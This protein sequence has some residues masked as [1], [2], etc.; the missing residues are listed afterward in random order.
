MRHLAELKDPISAPGGMWAAGDELLAWGIFFCFMVPTFFLVLLLRQYE[1]SSS[2]Y[3]RVLFW[4]SLTAPLCLGIYMLGHAAH[5]PD[6]V[7]PLLWRTWRAPLVL[8][9]IAMSRVFARF[10]SA[11]C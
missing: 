7:D 9:F 1:H 11:N 4:I 8:M 6:K 5:M 3:S 2:F 10:D